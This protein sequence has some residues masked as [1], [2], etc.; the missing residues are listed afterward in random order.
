MRDHFSSFLDAWDYCILNNNLKLVLFRARLGYWQ[1][2]ILKGKA[3]RIY[4]STNK[5]I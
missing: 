3:G 4:G 2:H 1:G 5:K